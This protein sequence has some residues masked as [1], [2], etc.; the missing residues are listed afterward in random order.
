MRN[1]TVYLAFSLVALLPAF[2][3]ERT[4]NTLS[5]EEVS[6]G[7]IL[8]WDGDSIFGWEPQGGA[9]W[10][11]A[12]GGLR[13]S[14]GA[15]GWLRHTTPFANFVLRLEF[16]M[17]TL[18]TDSGIFIRAASE[19]DPTKTGYQVNI[20]NINKEYGSGSLVGRV[21]APSR[22]LKP[23]EW[24]RYQITAEND[25]LVVELDGEKVVDARD[26]S[27]QTGYIGL[28]FVKGGEIE[29]RNIALR[30]LGLEPLFNGKDLTGW[31][32]VDRPKGKAIPEWSVRE[33]A[34]HVEKGPGQLETIS[35]FADFVLQLEVC[36]NAENENHHPNSGVFFRGDKGKS[37]TGYEVQIRN[38]F[39]EDDRTQ[40]VDFGT[41]GLYHFQP[42]R[43]VVS[44]DKEF[45][46]KTIVAAG[47]H[48]AVWVNGIE[49]T[50]YDD[51]R[52]EGSNAVTEARLVPGPIALQAHDPTT[53]L[54][55]RNLRITPLPKR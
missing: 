20:N 19:G 23:K 52:T 10:K 51:A 36:A 13:A 5:P 26:G 16:R 32:S 9:E 33:G 18:E 35:E 28:Q 11:T 47:R 14:S 50:S 3:A 17:N 6:A 55:F 41:G 1:F 40:P 25:H 38:Q 30:P 7:W 27:A 45:F 15:G 37:W 48:I 54:D 39:K 42:A 34:I 22:R 31:Q 46:T 24:H 29:F 49:V 44:N 21:K 4:P 53:N 8:L 12:D 2:G 43:R